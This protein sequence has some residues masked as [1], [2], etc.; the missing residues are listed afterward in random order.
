MA[1]KM[2]SGD[3]ARERL[4]SVLREDRSQMTSATIGAMRKDI[5]TV[6]SSYVTVRDED[7]N[8]YMVRGTAENETKLMM[9]ATVRARRSM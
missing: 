1:K 3:V 7:V 8:F 4:K 6:L 5:L 9:E 2:S